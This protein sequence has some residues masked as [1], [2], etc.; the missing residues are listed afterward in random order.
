MAPDPTT[1][2]PTSTLGGTPTKPSQPKPAV[3][4]T[5]VKARH[6]SRGLTRARVKP[7]KGPTTRAV[8]LNVEPV[9]AYSKGPFNLP[10]RK[11]EFRL[12]AHL[13]SGK[14]AA[15]EEVEEIQWDDSSAV[16]TGTLNFR[17]PEWAAKVGLVDGNEVACEYRPEDG[18]WAP[19]W[20]MRVTNP[21]KTYETRQRTFQLANDLQR[22]IDSTDTFKF[23]KGKKKKNGWRADEVISY[24]LRAYGVEVAPGGMPRLRSYITNWTLIDQRPL[25]VVKSALTRERNVTGNRYT[26]SLNA[27]GQAVVSPYR[28]PTFL[29]EMGEVML[30]AAY[31]V[32]RHPR[33]ATAL[34]VRADPVATVAK[35]ARGHKKV[36]HD[37]IAV[38]LSSPGG[39]KRYGFVHRNVYSP[40]AG[41]DAEAREE[42]KQFLARVAKSTEQF[43]VT[44]PGMPTL[45]RLDAIRFVLP[46]EGLKQ[47][48]YV[49]DANHSVS[50]S[51]YQTTAMLAV[52]DPFRDPA[53]KVVDKLSDT[54]ITRAR[55]T[56]A[57]KKKKAPV[58]P[59]NK[60]RTRVAP[61][62]P[63][64]GNVRSNPPP[65]KRTGGG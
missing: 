60:T 35:D 43:P 9:P 14:I 31:N 39:V 15:L 50:G 29:Y 54:A 56:V 6:S 63:A 62:D 19:L 10:V 40:D 24:I 26:L 38:S 65:K 33:F 32:Q 7:K 64:L 42:G 13:T 16:M 52:D 11:Y 3:K 53:D 17:Q 2:H 21:A 12:W 8:S 55:K 30:S 18:A 47:L 58:A 25:D 4:P 22:L 57:T 49:T 45:R 20:L 27:T 36:S 61:H 37:K 23:V 5:R 28:R 46:A 1:G 59:R 44:L 51:G 48:V 41:T 34:T